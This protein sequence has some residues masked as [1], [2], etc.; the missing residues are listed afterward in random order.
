MVQAHHYGPTFVRNGLFPLSALSVDESN[1]GWREK[2]AQR[3]AELVETFL[4]G[5]FGLTVTCGVQVLETESATGKKLVD[6]GV[7]TV[8]ALLQCQEI[9]TASSEH[10]PCGQAWPSSLLDVFSKGLPCRVVTYA[11]NDDREARESWNVAKHDEEG[12]SV[13]WSSL[14]QKLNIVRCRFNRVGDWNAA[15]TSLLTLYGPGKRSTVGRWTRAARSV[16]ED[17][18]MALK[19]FPEMKG[20]FLWDN[21]YL[22][23]MAGQ[24]RS[25]L[26]TQAAC[27]AVR[28]L[29]EHKSEVTAA[30]FCNQVCKPL[31]ILEVWHSLMVKR[32]GSVASQSDALRRVM[33][34]LSTW[35]GLQ[36]VLSCVSSGVPLHGKGPHNQGIPEC[37]LL[38]SELEKCKA[39]GLGPPACVPT[40]AE[41]SAERAAKKKAEEDTREVEVNTEANAT[42]ADAEHATCADEVDLSLLSATHESQA[43][44]GLSDFEVLALTR[45][46]AAMR[47]IHF[48]NTPDELCNALKEKVQSDCRVSLLLDVP[49]TSVSS[50]CHLMDLAQELTETYRVAALAAVGTESKKFRCTLLLGGRWDLIAKAVEKGKTL[51]PQ[52]P[53]FVVQLQTKDRQSDRTRPTY[54]VVFAPPGEHTTS[55]PT[56]LKVPPISAATTGECGLRLRCTERDCKWRPEAAR[57][58]G[59]VDASMEL[60]QEDR[61]DLLEA[62]LGEMAE[63]AS[64][65]G[66]AT[67][68]GT[69]E[70]PESSTRDCV[71]DLWPFARAPS[72]YR[73]ILC[74]LASADKAA[75]AIVISASAHP[76][77]W[78]ACQSLGLQTLVLTRR[79]SEHSAAHG[80][81]LGKQLLRKELCS[82]LQP[83]RTTEQD[84]KEIPVCQCMAAS[85]KKETE[86]QIIEAYD[87][88]QGSQWCDGLNLAIPGD[89]VLPS[90]QALVRVEAE[91]YNLRISAPLGE[92]GRGLETLIPKR[93]GE[94]VCKASALFFDS[95]EALTRF[96]KLSNGRFSDRIAQVDGV[97]RHQERITVWAVL[98]GV[99]QY[100]Q[101]FESYRPRANTILEFDASV[102]F[103]NSG[104]GAL[105]LVVATRTGVGI[106]AG[107]P[108]LLNYGMYFDFSAMCTKAHTTEIQ[109]ALNVIFE[110]Q[111]R[112]CPQEALRCTGGGGGGA[113]GLI[114]CSRLES[115]QTSRVGRRPCGQPL[116]N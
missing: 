74:S 79:W 33:S 35:G 114:V 82:E 50:F 24:D 75:L 14:W 98:I 64:R 93:D 4:M 12:N 111:R 23:I 22:V 72:Y 15:Q 53:A 19:Q 36:S 83:D 54:A 37:F 59:V 11:D 91:K 39:G 48:M 47:Y 32:Y 28:L 71:V 95:W 43:S 13:R 60:N 96:L 45:L 76:G 108:V 67:Q 7:S 27:L 81:E 30:N 25:R 88:S 78:L 92:K 68:E 18:M 38:V 9:H 57:P 63:T 10:T 102:G 56:I 106:A 116:P 94:V 87:V 84:E 89:T 107:A 44:R 8:S 90:S 99:A 86:A 101:H 42:A 105:K 80:L 51:W 115:Q 52:W 1:T 73:E 70:E 46:D 21:P 17:F 29:Y 40:E 58:T 6:D 104:E 61:V 97:H 20:S 110:A 77:H 5:N 65:E 55:E 16:E 85:L 41:W 100:V 112:H 103:N 69:F 34:H 49:T 26:S 2:S 31:K 62:M 113:A 109:G 66:T 3:I